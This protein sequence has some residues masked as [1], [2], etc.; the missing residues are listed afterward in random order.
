MSK[1][2][3]PTSERDSWLVVEGDDDKFVT[4][5][6]LG[7]HGAQW[8][9]HEKGADE[10][11]PFV[12]SANGI[13]PLREVIAVQA[14]SRRR[15]GM[16]F[17]ADLE[18]GDAWTKVRDK[19]RKIQDPPEWLSPILARIPNLLP[20]EGLV[21]EQDRRALGVWVMPDNGARG[22][23]E[24]FLVD[25]VPSGDVHWEHARA[26]VGAAMSRGVLFPPQYR[27]KAEV[28]TW[29]AWQREPGV[30]LGRAV[31]SAYFR[32]DS[33]GAAAFVAWFQRMFPS[34]P[35]LGDAPSAHLPQ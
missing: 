27:S 4:I 28:H 13:G 23:L 11:L 21:I 24:E 10:H 6:L 3:P 18:A 20:A 25:L 17:D 5:E 9:S 19:L 1:P 31:K 8:G 12:K 33:A 14:K 7:R 34:A 22:A 15:L 26:S 2:G 16:I 32:H 35:K 29:L 30:P